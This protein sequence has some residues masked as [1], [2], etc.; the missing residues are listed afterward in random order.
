MTRSDQK[1]LSLIDYVQ[2]LLEI[3]TIENLQ[4]ILDDLV[5]DLDEKYVL[6]DYLSS[7]AIFL[8]YGY[9]HHANI[10]IHI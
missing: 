10:M 7:I 1:I 9:P 6:A 2:S 4:N 5:Q 3:D 8:K